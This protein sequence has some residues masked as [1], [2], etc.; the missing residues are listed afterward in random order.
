MKNSWWGIGW[1]KQFFRK[2]NNNDN[3]LIGYLSDY[4]C[5]YMKNNKKR[6]RKYR[7]GIVKI[8]K[9]K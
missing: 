9:E 6:K 1:V 5:E 2:N 8:K 3:M 4:Q 7:V